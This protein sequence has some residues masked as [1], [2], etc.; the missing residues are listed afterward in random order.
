MGRPRKQLPEAPAGARRQ[1]A[2]DRAMRAPPGSFRGPPTIL[3]IIWGRVLRVATDET[4]ERPSA[5]GGE[6]VVGGAGEVGARGEW[7][8]GG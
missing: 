2:A 1:W 7:L 6:E 3:A 4:G 5:P 8:H